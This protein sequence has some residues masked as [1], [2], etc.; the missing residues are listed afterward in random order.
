MIE[1]SDVRQAQER[2]TPYILRTPLCASR[3]LDPILGCQVYLKHEGLQFTR[4]LQ[5]A[6]ATNALLSLTEEERS[7]GVVAASS[8]NHARGWP[9]R[10]S[11][12]G[13]TR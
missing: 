11:G 9:V 4:V 8:G 1:L 12:W 6:G 2:I 10:P 5:A 13:W 3:A 7:R